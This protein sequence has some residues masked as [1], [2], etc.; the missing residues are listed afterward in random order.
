MKKLKEIYSLISGKEPKHKI[1]I[2]LSGGGAL[3][4]AHIGVLQ[5]LEDNQIFPEAVSGSSMGSIIGAMYA[6]GYK[7]EQMLQFIK[8]GKLYRITHIMQF[9]PTFWKSG[10]SNHNTIFS[11]MNEFIP[12][13]SFLKLEKSLHVCVTNLTSGKWEIISNSEKLDIWIAASCSIPGIFN[14]MKINN[15]MYVDGGL[16]NNIPA[17]P[18]RDSCE[19]VIGSDVIPLLPLKKPLKSR[20]TLVKSLRVAQHQNSQPGRNLCDILIEP[21][22][23]E[24]YHE[25]SYDAYQSIYQYGYKAAEKMI[26]ERKSELLEAQNK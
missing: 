16:L 6:A 20:E 8:E 12:N 19:I 3:G 9:Q 13:N 4:F 22:A 11:V 7:P 17:Q 21:E 25:F 18:L 14:A 24:K 10:L 26:S 2:C 23:I 5:A 1:G 15:M